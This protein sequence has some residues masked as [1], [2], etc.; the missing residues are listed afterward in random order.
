MPT[1]SD[2][3][4]G[5]KL[6]PLTQET[7]LLYEL[8]GDRHLLTVVVMIGASALIPVP[9]LD[10]VAKGY[11]ERRLLRAIARREKVVLT[12]AEVDRL[13]K[14]GPDGCFMLGCL[15]NAVLY[16]VKKI[17]RKIFFFLEVKRTVDQSSRALAEAWLFSLA[18]R[19]GLW[20]T[21]RKIEEADVLRMVID[22]ACDSQGVKPLEMAFQQVFQSAKSTVADF[23]SRFTGKR[24]DDKAKLDA[25]LSKLEAEESERLDGLAAKLREAMGGLGEDYLQRF[26]EGFEKQLESTKAGG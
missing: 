14:E 21:G 3:P 23:V 15:G 19:R 8:I 4:R 6:Q 17:L 10:D 2:S 1:E 18:L 9:F 25:A 26:A 12:S 11:L 16:P 13:T 5:D 24:G 7:A 20:G 22:S